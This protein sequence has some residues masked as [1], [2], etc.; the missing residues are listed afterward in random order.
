MS[1]FHL[2]IPSYDLAL[3]K[4]FYTKAFGVKIGREY[5][6]YVIFDFLEN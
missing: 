2:A 6:H 1:I 4:E 3:S 5:S